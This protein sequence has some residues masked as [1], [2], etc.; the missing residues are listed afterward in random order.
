MEEGST[1]T[2]FDM[3]LL[4]RTSHYHIGQAA[5][6]GVAKRNERVRIH[7]HELVAEF[8]HNIVETRK[9]TIDHQQ[10]KLPYCSSPWNSVF[11]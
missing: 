5:V 1:T 7:Q 2:P 10:G 11:A 4:N 6:R 8:E 3:M 9:S